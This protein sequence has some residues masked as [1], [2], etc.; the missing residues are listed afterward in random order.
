V[1]EASHKGSSLTLIVPQSLRIS[2]LHSQRQL[3]IY[4]AQG[5]NRTLDFCLLSSRKL[6]VVSRFQLSVGSK[7]FNLQSSAGNPLGAR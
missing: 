7:Y 2:D 4:L 6:M 3:R 1:R 5:G